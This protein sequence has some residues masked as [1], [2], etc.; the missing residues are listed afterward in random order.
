MAVVFE[1]RVK[2]AVNNTW[3]IE[4]IDTVDNRLEMCKNIDVFEEKIELLGQ[5]Y[6][7]NIDEVRWL[8][9]DDVSPQMMDELRM[10]MSKVKVEVES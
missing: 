2:R 1:A 9:D 8:K 4:L 7:G 3:Y 6:G 10:Q 5:D